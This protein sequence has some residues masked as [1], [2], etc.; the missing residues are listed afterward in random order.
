MAA[1]VL[2]LA[3]AVIWGA[4]PTAP[5]PILIGV[6]V[7]LRSDGQSP[8][9]A[10]S[11]RLLGALAGGAAA[12]LAAG[13]VELAPTLLVLAAVTL[14]VSRL[15]ARQVATTGRRRAAASKALNAMAILQGQGLSALYD[16][17]DERFWL[18]LGSVLIGIGIAT[19]ALLLIEQLRRAGRG[20]AGPDRL[21]GKPSIQGPQTDARI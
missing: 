2:L 12:V 6:I 16:D 5:A 19:V 1:G 4:A 9:Q 14:A 15:I 18:R 11:D 3:T 21:R 8:G 17:T 7:M 20:S 10:A 13:L